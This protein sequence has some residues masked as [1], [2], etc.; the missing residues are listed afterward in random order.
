ME[1]LKIDEGKYALEYQNARTKVIQEQGNM[2]NNRRNIEL[3]Q[4]VFATTNLQY[5]KGTTDMTDSLNA[6]NSLKEAQNNYL[7][8]VYNFFLARI[9]LEKA[10]GSLK[11]FYLA[12]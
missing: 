6:Q 4:S 2:D 5:Q 7:S 12:L 8:S 3:A 11:T 9:D 10:G 1:Q